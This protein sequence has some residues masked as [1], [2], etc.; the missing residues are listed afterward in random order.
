MAIPTT[1]PV[2]YKCGHTEK[3]DL[4]NVAASKTQAVS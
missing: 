4:S 2:K 3:R 1:F